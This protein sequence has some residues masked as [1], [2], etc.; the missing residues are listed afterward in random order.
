MKL[1]EYA[2]KLTELAEKHPDV[3]VVYAKDDDD[4]RVMEFEPSLGNFG[5]NEFINDDN[6]E[7]FLTEFG[8]NAVCLN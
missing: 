1:K 2:K 8:V 4:F 6:T 7:E 5:D 3:E